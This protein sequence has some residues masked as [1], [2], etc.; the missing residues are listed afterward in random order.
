MNFPVCGWWMKKAVPLPIQI[1]GFLSTLVG[2]TLVTS[3]STVHQLRSFD[4][5]IWEKNIF[6]LINVQFTFTHIFSFLKLYK[7]FLLS[8]GVMP[9]GINVFTLLR[10]YFLLLQML[11]QQRIIVR[12]K[13][14]MSQKH[15]ISNWL[16]TQ[17]QKVAADNSNLRI[18]S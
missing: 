11:Q 17:R 3:P 10:N 1:M 8:L 4:I 7:T 16:L 12:N 5:Y 15:R 14:P 6:Q 2:Q 13:T 18:E 9:F